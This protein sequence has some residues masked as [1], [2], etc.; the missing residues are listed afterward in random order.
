MSRRT[1][2]LN[3]ECSS[4]VTNTLE[5]SSERGDSYGPGGG[6]LAARV[7]RAV[8]TSSASSMTRRHQNG[9]AAH[10]RTQVVEAAP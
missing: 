2:C 7:R 5:R 1:C 6:G 8:A 3:A 4:T 10:A 9:I